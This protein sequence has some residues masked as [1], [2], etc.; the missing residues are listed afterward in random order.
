MNET[1]VTHEPIR[2]IFE[3]PPDLTLAELARALGPARRLRWI[4]NLKQGNDNG[5]TKH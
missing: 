5:K 1:N 2:W 4:P 3:L